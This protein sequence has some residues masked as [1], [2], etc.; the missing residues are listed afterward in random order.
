MCRKY[1]SFKKK[2]RNLPQLERAEEAKFKKK[3]KKIT[4]I[5]NA[6]ACASQSAVR[7]SLWAEAFALLHSL[8]YLYIQSHIVHTYVLRLYVWSSSLLCCKDCCWNL[9]LSQSWRRL[10]IFSKRS[11]FQICEFFWVRGARVWIKIYDFIKFLALI[12]ASYLLQSCVLLILKWPRAYYNLPLVLS[13]CN[14]LLLILPKTLDTPANS[15]PTIRKRARSCTF[16]SNPNL[17]FY[18]PFSAT[19]SRLIMQLFI[20]N[21]N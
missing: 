18:F 2:F 17:T 13:R 16:K 5:C 19:R 9:R 14:R 20:F 21:L 7:L 10:N 1:T 15:T 4:K 11:V 6:H 8:L 12:Y 3:K